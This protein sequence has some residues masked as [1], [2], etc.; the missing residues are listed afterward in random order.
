MVSASC[1]QKEVAEAFKAVAGNKAKFIVADLENETG[2]EIKL[3]AMGE[4][5]STIDDL[6]AAVPEDQPR[7]IIYNLQWTKD[8]G[9]KLSKLIFIMFVPDACKKLPLKFQYANLKESFKSACQPINKEFQINDH[10][11]LE[12]N[13]WI[14]SF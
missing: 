6:K 2:N 12:E 11:E 4:L 10:L 1:V 13:E 9:R 14:S 8:D 5:G 3:S 7:F